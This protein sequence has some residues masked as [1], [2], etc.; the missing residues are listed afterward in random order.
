MCSAPIVGR[1]FVG[2]SR[3]N[4]PNTA[5]APQT[6]FKY[7]SPGA[8]QYPCRSS[9]D[10][11]LYA[12]GAA[13]GQAAYDLNAV[14]DDAYQLFTDSR[15]GGVQVIADPDP[16][17]G[18]SQVNKEESKAGGPVQPPPPPGIP[19]SST[20]A[21]SNVVYQASPGQPYPAMKFGSTVCQ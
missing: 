20:T 14:G 11:I 8:N 21:S 18:G 1:V 17:R 13:T 6:P 3:L 5:F 10:S 15:L 19:P 7:G 2:G 16:G 12:L 9:F 4:L